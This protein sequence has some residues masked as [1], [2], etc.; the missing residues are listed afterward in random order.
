MVDKNLQLSTFWAT[1]Y[2]RKLSQNDGEVESV[3]C[4]AGSYPS[5]DNILIMMYRL[6]EKQRQLITRRRPPCPMQISPA[7]AAEATE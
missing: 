7:A 3:R 6:V 4:L 2:L 5:F 1:L